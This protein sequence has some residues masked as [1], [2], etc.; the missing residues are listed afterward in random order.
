MIH[1][2]SQNA[3]E[4]GF[5][6]RVMPDKVQEDADYQARLLLVPSPTPE[7]YAAALLIRVVETI[8]RSG[9][10]EIHFPAPEPYKRGLPPNMLNMNM[11]G[12]LLQPETHREF[13]YL[14]ADQGKLDDT[15]LGQVKD[16][17]QKERAGVVRQPTYISQSQATKYEGE[18]ERYR[19]AA[20]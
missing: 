14:F 7:R 19:R 16:I 11:E 13:G 5:K 9:L 3:Y 12:Y 15:L 8:R 18:G 1:L 2:I 4:A 17:T 6:S 10:V 20:E